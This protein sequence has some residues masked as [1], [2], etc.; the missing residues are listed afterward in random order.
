M[1]ILHSINCVIK[2]MTSMMICSGMDARIHLRI[3]VRIFLPKFSSNFSSDY[4]WWLKKL[5]H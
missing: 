1:P 3:Y 5:S 2:E 4:T